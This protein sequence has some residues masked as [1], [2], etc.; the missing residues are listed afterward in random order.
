MTRN[1]CPDCRAPAAAGRFCSQCG[2]RLELPRLAAREIVTTT[3][4]SVLSFDGPVARTIRDLLRGPGRVA[5]A[6][7]DGRRT[8]YVH[9]V[10]FLFVIGVAM[11]LAHGPIQ[12][13]RQAL[14]PTGS[15][16]HSGGLVG[17]EMFGLL[18]IVLSLPL[19][20]VIAGVGA[21]F[22]VRQPWLEWYV[23]SAY[24]FGIG[25]L[26]QLSLDLAAIPLPAAWGSW[27]SVV[28]SAVPLGLLTWGAYALV[29][30]SRRWRAVVATGLAAG[31]AVALTAGVAAMLE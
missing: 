21:C 24:C 22:G 3:A 4:Q 30:R 9:P 18:V 20:L 5:R 26:L 16:M 17:A 10:K 6:W 7:I 28:Q 19:A 31:L 23:L 29:D 8:S 1:P 25:A 14:Q 11:L 12:Q 2:Q 15:A 13:L 27:L